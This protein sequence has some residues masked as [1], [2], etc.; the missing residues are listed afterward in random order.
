M[1]CMGEKCTQKL[2]PMFV[3]KNLEEEKELYKQYQTYLVNDR[4]EKSGMHGIRWCSAGCGAILTGEL[5]T[6]GA[7][8]CMGCGDKDH[9]PMPCDLVKVWKQI[10][11]ATDA[12]ETWLKSRTKPCP[13]CK[14]PIEKNEGCHHM[15]C[16]KCKFHWCWVCL[17]DWK[18]HGYGNPCSEP[19]DEAKNAEK[20][21]LETNQ[22]LTK[23]NF[24]FFKQKQVEE[25]RKTIA[26]HVDLLRT[27]LEKSL[28]TVQRADSI[29]VFMK[30]CMEALSF[31]GRMMPLFYFIGAGKTRDLL[32][33]HVDFFHSLVQTL[34][35]YCMECT[36]SKCEESEVYRKLQ[37]D[38]K[39]LET[40]QKH[41]LEFIISVDSDLQYKSE[42]N[43]DGWGCGICEHINHATDACCK[44]CT[45]C[46]THQEKRCVICAK[47]WVRNNPY[48]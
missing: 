27:E 1:T 31:Y 9:R 17:A 45:A 33:N 5:C 11:N 10:T 13:Q 44:K 18:Q 20:D 3:L 16:S 37:T 34:V 36:P 35:T 14:T 47:R 26:K 12:N 32:Q 19:T 30:K 48:Q 6:C 25:Q 39:L 40:R 24:Y 23:V 7:Y 21:R 41:L 43:V 28:I 46:V 2:S 22:F 38:S 29:V 15:S 4:M 8:T 42:G